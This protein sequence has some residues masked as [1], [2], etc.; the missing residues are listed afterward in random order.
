[1]PQNP[2]AGFGDDLMQRSC[3]T[4]G[5]LRRS[6]SSWFNGRLDAG[7][8]CARA[9]AA[10]NRQQPDELG[11]LAQFWYVGLLIK[12]RDLDAGRRVLDAVEAGRGGAASDRMTAVKHNVRGSLLFAMGSVD[13]AMDEISTGLRIAERCGDRSLRPPS[14]VV[15]ALG[16]LRRADMRACRHF[17]DKLSDEALL[18][19]FGQAPGAWVAAQAVEARS[20][21][22]SAASLIAGIVTNPVVLRQLL[23]SEPAAASW[24]VRA[25][26]KLG[27]HDLAKV[28]AEESAAMAAEQPEFSVIRGSALHAAGLLE[29][30]AA[31]LHE[32]ADIHPDRWCAASAREDL[33]SLLA[34]RCSE[35]DRTIRILESVLDTYAAVGATRDSA[36]VVNKLREYGVRRG[37]TRTVECEGTVP[38]GLTNTEFAVA[39]LVSQGHTNNEVGRQL[40][41]SRHTVAFHLK[42]VFQKM[43]IT[44]RVELAAAWKVFS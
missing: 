32:A 24:L 23:V 2:F 44:S 31:K 19:Y 36:R 16:A 22:D 15:L 25:C 38:H 30:D 17:V 3:D 11:Q 41:I 4:A 33:A 29:Q 28:S 18:G 10:S 20:G 35:R 8:H 27:A 9:A 14:Y 40:F 6:A 34:V 42:K 37:T 7:L 13:D 1:M 5:F 26:V 39:E 21:V 43:N 12:A